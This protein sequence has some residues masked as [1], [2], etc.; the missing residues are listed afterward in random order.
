VARGRMVS[1][2]AGRGCVA[3]TTCCLSASSAGADASTAGAMVSPTACGR[4]WPCR[5]LLSLVPPQRAL[6]TAGQGAHSA[7]LA[8]L[9]A[10]LV[11]RHRCERRGVGRQNFGRLIT[12]GR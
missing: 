12:G 11:A 1:R 10:P 7:A 6:A 8:S 5:V 4:L 3:A 2:S 9:L